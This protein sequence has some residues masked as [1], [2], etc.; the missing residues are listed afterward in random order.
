MLDQLRAGFDGSWLLLPCKVRVVVSG[1]VLVHGRSGTRPAQLLG[2]WPRVFRRRSRQPRFWP[3]PG[4]IWANPGQVRRNVAP[5]FGRI[6]AMLGQG[7]HRVARIRPSLGSIDQSWPSS[8][9]EW[10]RGV[11]L[12]R[13]LSHAWPGSGSMRVRPTLTWPDT[14]PTSGIDPCEPSSTELAQP[15]SSGL[16]ICSM[17]CGRCP[18]RRNAACSGRGADSF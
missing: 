10:P 16:D 11:Q 5:N 18:R 14:W 3:T 9:Q 7:R 15:I 4:R 13:D 17:L 12:W 8:G 1:G 6:W 2:S